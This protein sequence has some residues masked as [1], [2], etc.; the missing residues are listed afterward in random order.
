M[1]FSSWVSE[2]RAVVPDETIWLEV[3]SFSDI[4]L[5]DS[6][7]ALADADLECP[8]KP[9]PKKKYA[10][11]NMAAIHKILL[12]FLRFLA[13]SEAVL[14]SVSVAVDEVSVS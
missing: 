10:M 4:S 7:T 12:F 11:H 9:P 1:S 14:S 3:V 2:F 5:C 13:V 6:G 8:R